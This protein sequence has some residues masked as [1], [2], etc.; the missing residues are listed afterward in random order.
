MVVSIQQA[1]INAFAAY[2][3]TQ[4][5]SDIVIADRWPEPD[6]PLPPKAISILTSGN[7]RDIR[8][9]RNIQPT[10]NIGTS[11]VGVSVT[12]FQ[13]QQALQLD[14][15][16]LSDDERDDILAQLDVALNTGVAGNYVLPDHG[17]IVP[18]AD[19][20]PPGVFADFSFENPDTDDTADSAR[21]SEYRATYRGD[22]FV[23]FAAPATVARQRL[24]QFQATLQAGDVQTTS[25]QTG[26][27]S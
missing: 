26:T 5:S 10:G 7:R 16:A 22:L 21:T 19:G 1:S 23:M 24:I 25:V 27:T 3:K 13:C 4:L 12:L 9:E 15:W 18:V 20:Y 14:V 2:L 11:Q 6:Q 8:F 17:V